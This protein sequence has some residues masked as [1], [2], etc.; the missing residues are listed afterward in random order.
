MKKY[1]FYAAVIY[2]AAYAGN[3]YN[4]QDTSKIQP[5]LVPAQSAA[6]AAGIILPPDSLAEFKGIKPAGILLLE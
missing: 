1:L 5:G 6:K 4:V 2:G 3:R